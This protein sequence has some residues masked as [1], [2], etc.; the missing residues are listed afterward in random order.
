MV[1]GIDLSGR[2]V[3]VTGAASGIGIETARALAMT[4]AAVTLAV[5]DVAAGE[6]VAAD[7]TAT[8]ANPRVNVARLDLADLASVDAFT[9][10]WTGP[11]HV[12]INNAGIMLTP[13]QYTPQ[14]WEL[15]FADQPPRALGP[16][17]RPCLTPSPPT[18]PPGSGR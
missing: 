15:Q 16:R 12:L 8:A 4:G 10:A 17:G 3:V 11:L 1:A 13:P 9:E 6:R 14:G 5:R 2:S 7:I 18:G